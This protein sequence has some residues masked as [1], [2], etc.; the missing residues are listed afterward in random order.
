MRIKNYQS[1]IESIENNQEI[2]E[3]LKDWLIGG[4]IALSSIGVMKGQDLDNVDVK[5]PTTKTEYSIHKSQIDVGAVSNFVKKYDSIKSSDLT[6]T[7]DGKYTIAKGSGFYGSSKEGTGYN[8][9]SCYIVFGDENNPSSQISITLKDDGTVSLMYGG[10]K[11]TK[12]IVQY[13]AAGNPARTIKAGTQLMDQTELKKGDRG[14]KEA[15]DTLN[16][17]MNR[18]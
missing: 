14:Y 3:S 18:S 1:F 16:K 11:T 12:D 10:G 4:L 7:Q 2:N 5:S 6:Y 13:D 9:E 17:M 15:I 8:K